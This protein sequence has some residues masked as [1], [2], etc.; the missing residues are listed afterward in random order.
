MPQ[1]VDEG[2]DLG[3]IRIADDKQVGAKENGAPESL[4]G[5][6]YVFANAER[7]EDRHDQD[8]V[9]HGHGQWVSTRERPCGDTEVIR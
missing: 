6:A 7:H 3:R 8:H 2:A 5:R 1:V 9:D 4:V